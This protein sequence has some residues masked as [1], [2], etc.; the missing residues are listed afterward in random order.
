ML[1]GKFQE[2][3]METKIKDFSGD[4]PTNQNSN[5]SPITMPFPFLQPPWS[6]LTFLIILLVLKIRHVLLS[7]ILLFFGFKKKIQTLACLPLKCFLGQL[8]FPALG[9]KVLL[10][11]SPQPLKGAPLAPASPWPSPITVVHLQCSC[12]TTVPQEL[13][14]RLLPCLFACLVHSHSRSTS[15]Q[16]IHVELHGRDWEVKDEEPWCLHLNSSNLPRETDTK[17]TS[18]VVSAKINLHIHSHKV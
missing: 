8:L 7:L 14:T 17:I 13:P 2:Q 12:Q 18:R 3:D 4:H 5:S 10:T 15:E 9:H 11:R 16:F 1:L 6:R